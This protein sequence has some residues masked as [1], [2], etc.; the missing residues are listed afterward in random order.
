MQI[1]WQIILGGETLDKAFSVDEFGKAFVLTDYALYAF[2]SDDTG[3]PVQVWRQEYDRGSGKKP[4]MQ[5]KLTAC[6]N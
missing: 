4:G 5:V 3:T 1:L 2:K 6:V